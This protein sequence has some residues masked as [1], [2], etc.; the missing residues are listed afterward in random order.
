MVGVNFKRNFIF[1]FTLAIGIIGVIGIEILMYANFLI[2]KRFEGIVA[3]LSFTLLF[4]S[5]ILL[6][7]IGKK[8]YKQN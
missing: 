7:Y 4:I 6:I 2:P 1:F 5:I 8:K 3:V